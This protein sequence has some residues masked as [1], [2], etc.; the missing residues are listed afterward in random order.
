MNVNIPGE[1]AKLKIVVN[2]IR[3]SRALVNLLDNAY[4][5]SK[6]AKSP[7]ITA[8]ARCRGDFICFDIEDNGR[9]FPEDGLP[10][11]F[12]NETGVKSAKLRA[13]AGASG[14]KS[15]WGSTGIG[16]AFVAAVVKKHGGV[17]KMYN[18]PQGGACV[19]ISIP[20]RQEV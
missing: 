9:G 8:S 5:A 11:F 4:L 16:L 2:L 7:L 1:C 13:G 12:A 14:Q 3:L 15:E 17:M 10:E 19:T 6:D 18:R 20:L